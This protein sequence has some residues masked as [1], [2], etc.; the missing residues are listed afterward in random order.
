MMIFQAWIFLRLFGWRIWHCQLVWKKTMSKICFLFCILGFYFVNWHNSYESC[1][2]IQQICL[3][4]ILCVSYLKKL[5]QIIQYKLKHILFIIF[6]PQT[7]WQCQMTHIQA[8]LYS[9]FN[10]SYAEQMRHS[11]C[12]FLATEQHDNGYNK[13]HIYKC[14]T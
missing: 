2:N 4:N 14:T 8:M 12:W 6:Y 3:C 9:Y 10:H 11:Y 13:L 7:S 5:K 1:I